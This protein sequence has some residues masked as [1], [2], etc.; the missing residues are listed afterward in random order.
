[1][2]RRIR[3]LAGNLEGADLGL[4][5]SVGGLLFLGIFVVYGA[6]SYDRLASASMLGQHYVGVKH[7]VMIGMGV[8]ALFTLANI[9][10]HT[11]RTRW[12][13][14]G[15]LAVGMGLMVLTLFG[16]ESIP[17]WVTLGG[18]RFQPVELTKL[19]L[20]VFLSERLSC[21]VSH[22]RLDWKNL[23][24]LMAVGPFPLFLVLLKQPNFGNVMTMMGVILALF[25]VAG[26]AWRK[27]VLMVSVPLIFAVMVFLK[28]AKLSRRLDYWWSGMQDGEFSYQVHQSLVGLGAGGWHGL[29]LG[30]SHN[31]FSFLPEAHTDF[32]FSV[33]GE[34][35]GLIGTLIVIC[36]LM[37]F[38]WC[39]L[40]IAA[41]AAD[42][43]GRFLATG[44]TISLAVYGVAN[45]AMVTG[46][47]P[48]VGVPL[49]FV[50]FG[51]TA[52]V[53]ALASVGIL[54]NIDRDS[55]SYRD[56][57]KRWDRRLL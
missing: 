38:I 46:I 14:W 24:L 6:G 36:L 3:G 19:A 41:R 37:T 43:F 12:L 20:I 25:L 5:F 22:R 51:G 40:G 27:L 17:R 49:P 4:L 28:V 15:G 21:L 33:L 52:M 47:I 54:L 29:G 8:V 44:L 42:A 11:Y 26:V 18:F 1:M 7:L 48:V 13:A 34:E 35:L 10:Y 56:M 50:S 30:N 55:R 9:N 23:A 16:D 57:Q 45:L 2:N 32:I 39:G 31:K 53:A